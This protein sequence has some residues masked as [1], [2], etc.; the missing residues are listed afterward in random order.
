MKAEIY[1][2]LVDLDDRQVDADERAAIQAEGCAAEI[3]A[4][5]AEENLHVFLEALWRG[6]PKPP[7]T[8]Y[9]AFQT[10]RSAHTTAVAARIASKGKNA[11]LEAIW[12]VLVYGTDEQADVIM[13]GPPAKRESII[14]DVMKNEWFRSDS[15]MWI[16]WKFA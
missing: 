7:V 13:R 4:W 3:A 1:R 6:I 10:A 9:Q 8:G 15:G 5:E 14:A 12:T 11:R 2:L 16:E